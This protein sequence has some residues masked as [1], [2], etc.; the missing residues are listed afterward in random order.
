ML[1]DGHNTS[2]T[3]FTDTGDR[4]VLLCHVQRQSHSHSYDI[5]TVR[6]IVR[7]RARRWFWPI[8]SIRVTDGDAQCPTD[9]LQ[10]ATRAI[11]DHLDAHSA[12]HS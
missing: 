2:V 9:I 4:Y 8:D 12:N 6:V 7:R 10:A 5:D 11:T 1:P 3:V